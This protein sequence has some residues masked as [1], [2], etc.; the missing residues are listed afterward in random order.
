MESITNI[1]LEASL[2]AGPGGILGVPSAC[3][4]VI[5][6]GGSDGDDGEGGGGN[7]T[8]DDTGV[9][10][11]DGSGSNQGI[12]D[13]D[14]DVGGYGG[15]GNDEAHDVGQA[16]VGKAHSFNPGN[17]ESGPMSHAM[18]LTPVGL[19]V[20]IGRGLADVFG[21]RNRDGLIDDGA[22]AGMSVEHGNYVGM[23]ADGG[24]AY[25]VDPRAEEEETDPVAYQLPRRPKQLPRRPDYTRFAK[26]PAAPDYI[27]RR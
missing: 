17:L 18:G 16:A 22:L 11:T 20:S 26:L 4:G 13:P 5:A 10:S 7:V 1:E 19:G 24:E 9:S 2:L 12:G 15:G 8:G 3:E 14:T 23:N 21:D 27:R 6:F 25:P